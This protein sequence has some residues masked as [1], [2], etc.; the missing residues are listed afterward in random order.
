MIFT[1]E[2]YQL[3]NI[4]ILRSIL[5]SEILHLEQT[6]VK[7]TFLH[8]NLDEDIYMQEPKEFTALSKEHM[9]CKLNRSLYEL[10]Q[11]PRQW[12]KKCDSFMYKSSFH[13]SEK[14]QCCYSNKYIDLRGSTPICG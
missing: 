6:N 14:D 3:T 2:R 10:K 4:Q 12:Y 9:V 13:G 5:V 7:T 8:E 1:K 11:A